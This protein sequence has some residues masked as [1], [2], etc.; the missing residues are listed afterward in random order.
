MNAQQKQ[1]KDSEYQLL[2]QL[3]DQEESQLIAQLE[4]QLWNQ[5]WIPLYE[6]LREQLGNWIVGQLKNECTVTTT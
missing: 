5:F 2:I 1:L 4:I 3:V 6:H